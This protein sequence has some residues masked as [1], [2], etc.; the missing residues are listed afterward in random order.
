MDPETLKAAAAIAKGRAVR[1]S[2]G[3]P[4]DRRDGLERLGAQRALEQLA[5]DLEVTAEEFDKKT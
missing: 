2:Q 1:A 5:R 3:H 4:G